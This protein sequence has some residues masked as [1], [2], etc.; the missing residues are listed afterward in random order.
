[1]TNTNF[2]KIG[3][4]CLKIEKPKEIP[5][6]ENLSLFLIDEPAE[7][8]E[9]LISYRVHFT[10]CLEEIVQKEADRCVSTPIRRPDLIVVPTDTGETR[11][12]NFRGDTSFY[13]VSVQTAPLSYEIWFRDTL[14]DLLL[15][16]PV[17]YAPFSLEKIMLERNAMILHSAYMCS[18]GKAVLFSAPSETGKST[19]AGLWEKYRGTYQVNGDRSLLIREEDGWYAYSWPICGSSEICLNER[20]PLQAIVMLKQAKVNTAFRFTG[21]AAFAEVSSQITVNSWD[22]IAKLKSIDLIEQL[23]NEIPVYRLECDISKEA[24]EV[25]EAELAN[26]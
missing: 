10:D 16:D 11:F 21:A 15:S 3:H 8:P 6:P 2:Y 24:V 5:E 12:I 18:N 23:L 22:R 14:G 17:F 9:D 19:Q 1:M 26:K 13:A 20:H 4:T 25:L 7:A